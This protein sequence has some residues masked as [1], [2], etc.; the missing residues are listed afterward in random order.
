MKLNTP[1]W[2][3]PRDARHGAWNAG[4]AGCH[5]PELGIASRDFIEP[6]PYNR[7]GSVVPGDVL[8][9]RLSRFLIDL[10]KADMDERFPY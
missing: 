8:V 10:A 6:N 5:V 7:P 9:D 1:R 3:Y 2:W 4:C